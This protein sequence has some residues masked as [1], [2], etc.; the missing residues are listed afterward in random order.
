MPHPPAAVELRTREPRRPRDARHT[1][2]VLLI[3]LCSGVPR[4]TEKGRRNMRMKTW[5]DWVGAGRSLL[6]SLGVVR[7]RSVAPMIAG[8]AAGALVAGG[9][10]VGFVPRY[11][12]AL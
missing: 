7:K 1:A 5:N 8:I 4:S 11:R 10:L 2:H 12:T 6:I 9:A 3:P